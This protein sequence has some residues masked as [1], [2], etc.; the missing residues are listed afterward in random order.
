MLFLAMHNPDLIADRLDQTHRIPHEHFQQVD[1]P[2]RNRFLVYGPGT[3]GSRP[4][5]EIW[6]GE[7]FLGGGSE[8][9]EFDEHMDQ[10]MFDAE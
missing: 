8:Y 6:F 10:V 2:D 3:P 4:S 9:H 7:D 1:G 5:L